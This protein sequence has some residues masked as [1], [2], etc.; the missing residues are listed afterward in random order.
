ML[1]AI[2]ASGD[3]ESNVVELLLWTE[4]L[5]LID[6]DSK[7]FA[8]RKI[9]ASPQCFRKT[10]FSELFTLLVT[11]FGYAVGIKREDV[12]GHHADFLGVAFPILEEAEHGTGRIE[13][14]QCVMGC[15][16]VSCV[17]AAQQERG[18]MT[19]IRI[20]QALQLVVIFSEE[21]RGVG[22]VGGVLV[23][24][25][26]DGLQQALRLVEGCGQLSA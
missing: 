1:G 22:I 14:L 2:A 10:L 23:E 19:A 6:E 13:T 11:C 17:M 15:C 24:E 21:E 5:H 4:A 25:L 26:I 7:Q 20:A 9:A 3:D 16:V 8:G 12:A 18:K